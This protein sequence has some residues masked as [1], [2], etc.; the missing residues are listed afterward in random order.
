MMATNLI[1]VIAF[2]LAVG[3]GG[4]DDDGGDD[5]GDDDG[6]G[7]RDGGVDGGAD[8]GGPVEGQF[9]L[10]EIQW[11]EDGFRTGRASGSILD[12]RPRYHE[13]YHEEGACRMWLWLVSSCLSCDG[14]CDA[15][16]RC[17]PFR[18]PLSAGTVAIEVNGQERAVL[19]FGV[20]GYSPESLAEELF[21]EGDRVE[22]SA[23]GGDDVASFA[24][25]AT[26]VDAIAIDLE[27]DPAGKDQDKLEMP[28]GEDLV[29]SWS[30]SVPG[31]RVRLE[32][33]SNNRGHG[34]PVDALIECEADD[35]GEITVPSSMVAA[36][37]ERPYGVIC[38]GSDCPPGTLTRF[39][40]DRVEVDG[41]AIDLVV[42]AQ[43]QFVPVHFY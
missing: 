21:A 1:R 19:S 16:G 5:G 17:V 35:S 2:V 38:A 9:S 3:C 13:L 37:P 24:L 7:S 8:P 27:R 23:A 34:L 10:L 33:P 29:L 14:I 25:A 12:P 30:P 42:G 6:A 20:S 11:G 22:A 15:E 41:G 31:T 40:A 4:G 36:F 39:R 26:A 28:N 18:D 43:R 32:I